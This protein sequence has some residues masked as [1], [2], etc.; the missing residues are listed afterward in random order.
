MISPPPAGSD[1]PRSRRK[2]FRMVVQIDDRAH[3][4][5]T[6]LAARYVATVLAQRS[7]QGD[8]ADCGTIVDVGGRADRGGIGA[9]AKHQGDQHA[10]R[11]Y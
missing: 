3:Y 1:V 5:N 7:A 4:S 2:A 6:D 11:F 10:R 9:A 8:R